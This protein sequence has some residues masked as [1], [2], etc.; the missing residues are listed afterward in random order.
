MQGGIMPTHGFHGVSLESQTKASEVIVVEFDDQGDF[1][2]RTQMGLV[3]QKIRRSEQPLV[4]TYVHGWRN[5]SH[6][7]C[8]DL[9]GFREFVGRLK[10]SNGRDV[11]GVYMGWRGES[12]NI[13]LLTYLTF[14]NRKNGASK[15]AEG[16]I[17]YALHRVG[18]EARKEKGRSVLVAHSF[19]GRIVERAVAES[20]IAKGQGT[21]GAAASLPADFIVLINPATESLNARQLQ[22]ALN[23]AP[24]DPPTFVAIGAKN[25]G[26]NG[27][28]WPFGAHLKRTLGL[29]FLSEPDR[30]Y[31]LKLK[32]RGGGEGREVEESQHNEFIA[33]TTTNNPIL[34][35]HTLKVGKAGNAAKGVQKNLGSSGYFVTTDVE[36]RSDYRIPNPC[37][38]PHHYG[39]WVFQVDREI[40]NGHSNTGNPHGIFSEEMNKL[41]T[42][43]V[44]ASGIFETPP[45]TSTQSFKLQDEIFREPQPAMVEPSKAK[46]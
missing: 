42:G 44:V 39:Y 10:K 2:D 40:L 28:A 41:V 25:D 31:I 21:A 15:V 7:E 4:V 30:K 8:A 16:S 45:K 46:Q 33:K 20:V 34:F 37:E 43:L 13:P 36:T 35:S 24:A 12:T 23:T 22:L 1:W 3:V 18:N 29:G 32:Q 14:W 17:S 11:I 38:K 19:G 5:N 6:P 9:K 26:A 27:K